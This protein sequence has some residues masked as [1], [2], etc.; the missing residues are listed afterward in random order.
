MPSFVL[1]I[2][3]PQGVTLASDFTYNSHYELIGDVHAL[4]LVDLER[5]GLGEYREMLDRMDNAQSNVDF[6]AEMFALIDR[7]N[8]G[9]VSVEEAEK[10]LLKLKM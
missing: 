2:K 5:E 6:I 10:I 3:P 8:N 1:E 7:D 4:R 9:K